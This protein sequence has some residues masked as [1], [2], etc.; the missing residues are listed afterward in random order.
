MEVN[1]LKDEAPRRRRESTR[2]GGQWEGEKKQG[3]KD[4]QKV[5]SLGLS[6]ALESFG[7]LSCLN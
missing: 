6:E 3:K 7:R 5:V 4:A 2:N 1:D